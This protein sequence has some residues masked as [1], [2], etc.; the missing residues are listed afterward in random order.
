MYIDVFVCICLNVYVLN[1]CFDQDAK[2]NSLPRTW[3]TAMCSQ[4]DIQKISN[5]SK[6]AM[7]IPGLEHL[8]PG[9]CVCISH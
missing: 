6:P 8:S 5:R 4:K 9:S 7:T 3:C 1:F 2:R